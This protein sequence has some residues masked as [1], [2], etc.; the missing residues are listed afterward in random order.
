VVVTNTS[1]V[2]AVVGSLTDEWPGKAAFSLDQACPGLVGSTLAAGASSTPCVFN[3]ANY[4][5]AAGTSLTNTVKAL[6]HEVGATGNTAQGQSTSTVIGPTTPVLAVTVNKVN[7]A[8]SDGTFT[9]SETAKTVGQTVPFQATITNTSATP[10]VVGALTDEWPGMP[11]FTL[12]TACSG[13]VGTTLDPGQSKLCSFSETNYGPASGASLT[14]T[15]KVDVHQPGNTANTAHG[16]STSTVAGPGT[17][18]L[19][20]TV[21]K[22]NDAN[23]DGTFTGNESASTPGAPVPFKA[24]ITN[25]SSVDV[26]ITTLT[27]EW[28]NMPAFD[29]N[30]SCPNV[31][32]AVLP[33]G[34]SITCS[35][36]VANYSP[37][38]GSDRVNTVRT[39]VTERN[40]PNNT[41]PGQG[42]STVRSLTQ[43]LPIQITPPATPNTSP[44]PI[45]GR[46][47]LVL[48]WLGLV[49]TLF[50]GAILSLPWLRRRFDHRG[51]PILNGAIF[52]NE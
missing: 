17:P 8:N 1:A 48:A 10:V 47:S 5:P 31:V 21:V 26:V 15:V 24:V 38:V 12:A 52:D 22:T 51:R 27:D 49:L 14:D 45:T 18:A 40:N 29:L 13:I 35:F 2:P 42:S 34:G 41:T 4:A 50:G 36:T 6:V 19:S 25:T 33:P 43:V 9:K 39:T 16:E 3:E 28:P 37:P 32:G 30:A 11:A 23:G 44:L 46:N 20:V 7:D